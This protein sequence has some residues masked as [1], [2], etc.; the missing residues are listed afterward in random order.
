MSTGMT[1]RRNGV[2]MHVG[3]LPRGEGEYG[4][5]GPGKWGWEPFR[6]NL[7]VALGSSSCSREVGFKGHKVSFKFSVFEDRN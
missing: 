2:F 4:W 5:E 3:L 1:E 6:L 7:D